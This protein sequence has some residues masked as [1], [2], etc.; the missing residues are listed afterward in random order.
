MPAPAIWTVCEFA[1]P[2]GVDDATAPLL[3]VGAEPVAEA[4][5]ESM[6]A[7]REPVALAALMGA[8]ATSETSPAA[9]V[10]L[11]G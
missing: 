6:E 5:F 4:I 10:W 1:A 9:T 8:D 11:V 3:P 2:V 7:A